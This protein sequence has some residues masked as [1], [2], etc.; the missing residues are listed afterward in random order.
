MAEHRWYKR[1][2]RDH[3]R[4]MFDFGN[5]DSVNEKFIRQM[6]RVLIRECLREGYSVIV[7]DTNCKDR[8]VSEIDTA[9]CVIPKTTVRVVTFD[10]PLAEC[11][12][13]D[14]ARENPIGER[15]ITEMWE[16]LNGPIMTPELMAAMRKAV[17]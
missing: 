1:V 15:R 3:L 13:R 12:E 6:R 9:A 5:Y 4:Q 16:Q 11:I 8:D 17:E 2:S 7:D 14:A 10:T